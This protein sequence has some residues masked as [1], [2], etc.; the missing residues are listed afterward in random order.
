M[1]PHLSAGRRRRRRLVTRRRRRCISRRRRRGRCRTASVLLDQSTEIARQ[2]GRCAHGIATGK[3]GRRAHARGS[4]VGRVG[5][6]AGIRGDLCGRRLLP[7][8]RT[9]TG[10]R[11]ATTV[12]LATVVVI[13]AMVVVAT[14]TV[15]S[16]VTAV[17]TVSA[18]APRSRATSAVAA[19]VVVAR[20]PRCRTASR[21]T[22]PR[23][24]IITAVVVGAWTSFDTGRRSARSTAKFLH[25]LLSKC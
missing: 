21:S 1:P 24:D 8:S 4:A 6:V 16:A 22:L 10:S 12:A 9:T 5:S 14:S 15:I 19:R 3:T 7:G 13:A 18:V 17:T 11:G 25:K 20:P 2:S 23:L